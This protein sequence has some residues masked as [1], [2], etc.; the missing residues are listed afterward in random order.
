MASFILS[1]Q[2]KRIR[3]PFGNGYELVAEPSENHECQI[4]I[5][6]HKN[7]SFVQDLAVIEATCDDNGEVIGNLFDVFLYEDEKKE[8]Y[9]SKHHIKLNRGD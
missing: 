7:G 6:I 5:E 9:T 2:N 8:G 1:R 3:I 4:A